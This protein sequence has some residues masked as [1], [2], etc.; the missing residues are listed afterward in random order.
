MKRLVLPQGKSLWILQ[1]CA[2]P[3]PYPKEVGY[4]VDNR[5]FNFDKY[6]CSAGIPTESFEMPT[7]NLK[8]V[9]KHV[10]NEVIYVNID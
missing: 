4:I 10:D 7:S 1:D 3:F 5:V 6:I 9:Y 2:A 8:E